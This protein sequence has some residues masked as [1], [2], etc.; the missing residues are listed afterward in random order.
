MGTSRSSRGPKGGVP[1]VPAWV[2]APEPPAAPAA[3]TPE[4]GVPVPPPET[5][6]SATEAPPAPPSV[7]PKPFPNAPAARF[8]GARISLGRF[9]RT[10]FGG[11]LA[12]G[13]GRYVRKGLGG[14]AAG[15]A[16]MAGTAKAAGALFGA[17]DQIRSGDV[18]G[19]DPRLLPSELTGKTP[20]QIGDR[21][22]DSISP[23]NGTLDAEAARWA[24]GEATSDLLAQTPDADL[25]ALTDAQIQFLTERFIGYDL[26]YR[27]QLDIGAT[28]LEKAPDHLT[29]NARLDQV[30][31]YVIQKTSA[32][33]SALLKSGQVLTRTTAA[34]VAEA[35][36]RNTLVVFESF[37]K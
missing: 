14:S 36:L 32:A 1:L 19:L 8:V 21:L 34:K 18:A 29:G 37:T 4:P 5:P 23:S 15:S 28:V 7:P 16:R 26:A 25:R 6:P 30:R 10:G 9:S 2:P 20:K 27:I 3:P 17:L 12:K 33:F 22:A 11:D 31:A 13:L 24:V 35:V